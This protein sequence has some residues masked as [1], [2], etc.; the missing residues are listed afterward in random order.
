MTAE[1]VEAKGNVDFQALIDKARA[2][3]LDLTMHYDDPTMTMEENAA[4]IKKVIGELAQEVKDYIE[5]TVFI[6]SNKR[7]GTLQYIPRNNVLTV[8]TLHRDR[9]PASTR[10]E[11]DQSTWIRY[12]FKIAIAITVDLKSAQ[13]QAAAVAPAQPEQ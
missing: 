11:D 13:R 8:T 7:E 4:K 2:I 9:R 3:G 10:I 12:G 1:A 5:P 6:D